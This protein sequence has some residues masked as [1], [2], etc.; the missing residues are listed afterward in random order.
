MSVKGH[1]VNIHCRKYNASCVLNFKVPVFVW[2]LEYKFTL[3]SFN[4]KFVFDIMMTPYRCRV[5][6]WLHDHD[7]CH[8]HGHND[9]SGV[10]SHLRENVDQ[11]LSRNCG[12]LTLSDH[13]H[14]HDRQY[15]NPVVVLVVAWFLSWH[16]PT[17]WAGTVDTGRTD[18]A[19][20]VAKGTI[21]SW[22]S[23]LQGAIR[24]LGESREIESHWKNPF[25]WIFTV[26]TEQI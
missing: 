10:H 25:V 2:I 20:E 5:H 17:D 21:D 11:N 22:H 18:D 9:K 15:W 13:V 23:D 24:T 19:S 26:C 12:S 1:F 16:Y 4:A 6:C 14:D 3:I 8:F 7:R